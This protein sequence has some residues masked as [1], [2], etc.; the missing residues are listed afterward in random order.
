MMNGVELLEI[1]RRS[2]PNIFLI[3]AVE[4]ESP[5]LDWYVNN[6]IIDRIIEINSLTN[7]NFL[8]I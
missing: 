7:N 6:R 1:I 8:Q 3:L 5:D 4:H 2:N